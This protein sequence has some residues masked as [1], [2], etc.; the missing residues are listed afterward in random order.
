MKKSKIL[1]NIIKIGAA[2]GAIGG[3]VFMLQRTNKRDRDTASRYRQ[4]YELT[5]QWLVNKNEEKKIET[6]F[7]DNEY[8]TIAIYGMGTLAELLYEEIKR[9]DIKVAYFIDKN[10]EKFYLGLDDIPVINLEDI[11]N[12]EK[13]DA[14]IVTPIYDFNKIEE[15]LEVY[16]IAE[17]VISLEDIIFSV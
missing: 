9:F 2:V 14:V 1:V 10:S 6:F 5:N 17:E 4:Y 15:N 16:N 3:S 12:Q 8:K 13:V 11:M 7:K